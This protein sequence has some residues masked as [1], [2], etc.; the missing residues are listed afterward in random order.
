MLNPN[1]H[2]QVTTRGFEEGWPVLFLE[3]LD[4]SVKV[5]FIKIH[6]KWYHNEQMATPEEQRYLDHVWDEEC[7]KYDLPKDGSR[8]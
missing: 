2:Y 8:G 5:R 7:R 1:T 6:G 3:T 4:A